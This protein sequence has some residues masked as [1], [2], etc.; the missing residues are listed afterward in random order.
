[1][2][3][4]Y[5]LGITV[6]A[7]FLFTASLAH[8]KLDNVTFPISELGGCADKNSCK[9]YCDDSSHLDACLAF[10]EKQNLMSKDELSKA[11]G[12][13]K[14]IKSKVS[15]P[16]GAK[17]PEQAKEYC[18]DTSHMD[19]CLSFAEKHGFVSK[20]EAAEGRKFIPVL[21][22]GETP[23]GC[24]TRE[25]CESFCKDENNFETCLE[26]A[27]K[28]KLVTDKEVE[29]AKKFREAGGPGGC[30]SKDE[31]ASF[32]NDPNN[33]TT[34]ME[35]AEKNG[36][37]SKQEI[38]SIK[39]GMGSMRA[40]LA[41]NPEIK[42]CITASV[43]SGVLEK[44]ETGVLTP[45][46]EV[47][48]SLRGCFEKH[49]SVI[50]EEAQKKFG[51][52]A[53]PQLRDCIKQQVGE[54]DLSALQNGRPPADPANAD[55]VR[56][57]YEKFN[58]GENTRDQRPQSQNND[59]SQNT[60]GQGMPESVRSCVLAKTGASD[61]EKVEKDKL[62]AASRAC[63][64]AARTA[65]PK[66]QDA[67]AERM[68]QEYLRQQENQKQE[69]G[70]KTPLRMMPPN[71]Q[72]QPINESNQYPPQYPENYPKPEYQPGLPTTQAP[73]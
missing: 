69:E 66:S 25:E 26:F 12:Y 54:Q 37:A 43:D 60:T 73:N 45:N 5:I 71:Y 24:K 61:L 28:H 52:Q 18:S 35:F 67:E 21:K 15:F 31:C 47:G 19:E 55:K 49:A 62:E 46:A 3:L 14:L 30:K 17:T 56:V 40:R 22:S 51:S 10:A 27:K 7:G 70:Q 2:K 36:L 29:V 44:I 13:A 38:Q 64:E 63:S 42:E 58:S 16:G 23:G 9:T 34:C 57:C 33:Q 1:M 4:K 6:F 48:N 32:C 72:P 50:Q 39:E 11:Q 41:D 68:K 59:D 53:A 8:A 65:R 20:T